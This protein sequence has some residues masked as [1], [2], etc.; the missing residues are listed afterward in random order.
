MAAFQSAE[1]KSKASSQLWV[2]DESNHCKTQSETDF[3]ED[4][5]A[6]QKEVKIFSPCQSDISFYIQFVY[7]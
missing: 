6:R 2:L 4:D 7:L 3:L 5:C 1:Q